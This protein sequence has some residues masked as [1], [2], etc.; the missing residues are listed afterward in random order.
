MNL[1]KKKL[2]G[3]LVSKENGNIVC[4]QKMAAGSLSFLLYRYGI[5]TEKKKTAIAQS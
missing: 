4:V 3:C 1:S 2:S 5:N